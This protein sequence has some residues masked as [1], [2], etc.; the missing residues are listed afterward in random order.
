MESHVYNFGVVLLEL[1]AGRPAIDE[2]RHGPLED[3]VKWSSPYLLRE[4]D[5]PYI[6]D[7][8]L[9]RKYSFSAAWSIAKIVR[10]CL[11]SSSKKWPSMRYIVGILE[12]LL[13]DGRKDGRLLASG[14]PEPKNTGF[15]R[16]FTGS[17]GNAKQDKEVEE[18]TTTDDVGVCKVCMLTFRGILMTPSS[19]DSVCE[20]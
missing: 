13:S 11:H 4:D 1:L 12:P 3:L 19:A 17:K 14:K 2:K 10:W 5:L 16:N 7:P 6:M 15:S 8:A 9:G 20:P 18:P